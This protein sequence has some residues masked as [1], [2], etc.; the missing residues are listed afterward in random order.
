[1]ATGSIREKII[2]NGEKR[3]EITVEG[4]K[5]S[6]TG[7]RNRM[8]KT[9]KGSKRE[10]NSMMHKMINEMDEGL[11]V[12][13]SPITVGQWM[14]QWVSLYLVNVEETTIVGYKGKIK[15][16]IKPYLGKILLQSLR[17]EHVQKMINDMLARGLSPKNARETFNNLN[18]AM[19]KAHVLKMVRENPC[20]AVE[21]PRVKRYHANVYNVQTM[22]QVLSVAEGKDIYLI[23]FLALMTGMRRG[24]LLALR[25]DNVD[26]DKKVIK[27]RS[28]MVR[29]ENAPVIK[30]PKTESGI[31]DLVIGDDVVHVLKQAKI[32]YLKDRMEQGPLFQDLGF[33]IR[34]KDGSPFTP[35]ALTRKWRRFIDEN[36]LPSIRFH[37]LRHSN[38]TALIQAGINPKV[39]QQR[40]GHADVSTT[41]SIYTHVLPEMD[42][43]AAATLDKI[44][45]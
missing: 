24:E 40:L 10:A 36:N 33:V 27:V 9:V 22:K 8:Y 30:E 13:K 34:Q 28:N 38:A 19:K 5:D 43:E 26:L 7:K 6:L 11:R 35:D 16:Y 2:K 1:M 41:L 31:R 32:Q 39:V 14:D 4:E 42:E 15:N 23:V 29:G 17:T 37:D 45:L 12:K 20:M 21:L 18:A 44:I 25:W 3:Y